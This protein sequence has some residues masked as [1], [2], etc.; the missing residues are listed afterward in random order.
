MGNAIRLVTLSRGND[1]ARCRLLAFGGAGPMHAA[2]LADAFH[3]SE[4]IIPCLPGVFST[5]GL[6]T[7]DMELE[8]VAPL[9]LSLDQVDP[10]QLEAQFDR[11]ERPLLD[12]LARSGFMPADVVV[13]RAL[14]MRYKSQGFD[15]AVPVDG[16]IVT[17][18]LRSRYESQ[19]A[20]EYE[21]RRDGVPIIVRACRV[22]AVGGVRD[23]WPA[24]TSGGTKPV[25]PKSSRSVFDF[26]SGN[27]RETPVFDRDD[28]RPGDPVVGPAI[29]E[30]R[31]STTVVPSGWKVLLDP[32]GN[33]VLR[34]D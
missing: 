24:T 27:Y 33:L 1:P 13:H 32:E 11:L 19:Y 30:E 28:L 5:L 2:T 29:V 12:E 20:G 10:A 31:E 14:D 6:V 18:D 16:P 34:R 22:R 8:N 25:R 3:I 9:W 21:V 23:S 26:A 15:L 17:A 4:V 7:S